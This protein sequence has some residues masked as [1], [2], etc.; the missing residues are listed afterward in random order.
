MLCYVLLLQPISTCTECMQQLLLTVAWIQCMW[1]LVGAEEHNTIMS[2]DQPRTSLQKISSKVVVLI[3]HT[4]FFARESPMWEIILQICHNYWSCYVMYCDDIAAHNRVAICTL[5]IAWPIVEVGFL[6]PYT[7]R[8]AT[9]PTI[10][11]SSITAMMT[12]TTT[13]TIVPLL[14]WPPAKKLWHYVKKQNYYTHSLIYSFSVL[15]IRWYRY[16]VTIY[17]H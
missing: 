13:P 9:T 15:W 3:T 1:K 12:T 14:C 17:I 16:R 2:I 6:Y 5:I 7:S 4:V 11:R 10:I 8:A